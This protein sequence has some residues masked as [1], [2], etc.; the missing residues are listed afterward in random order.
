MIT[1]K[2]ILIDGENVCPSEYTGIDKLTKHD[3]IVVFN[4]VFSEGNINWKLLYKIQQ[5]PKNEQPNIIHLNVERKPKD[6]EKDKMDYYMIAHI[7]QLLSESKTLGNKLKNLFKRNKTEYCIISKDKGFDRY[8][9]YFKDIYSVTVLRFNNFNDLHDYYKKDTIKETT[10]L[11]KKSK[12]SNK[13]KKHS[14][15]DKNN[16]NSIAI[17]N[18]SKEVNNLTKLVKD[19][20]EKIEDNNSNNSYSDIDIK[21]NLTSLS[22]NINNVSIDS[23][24]SKEKINCNKD[25]NTVLYDESNYVDILDIDNSN[26]IYLSNF[27]NYKEDNNNTIFEY[28][29][30]DIQTLENNIKTFKPTEQFKKLNVK[31]FNENYNSYPKKKKLLRDG[32]FIKTIFTKHNLY[33]KYDNK[34]LDKFIRD[35]DAGLI[36]I[37]TMT[38][39]LTSSFSSAS[40]KDFKPALNE[41][42]KYQIKNDIM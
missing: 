38:K 42:I 27:K 39:R 8:A 10:S 4:S 1:K 28:T 31:K 41:I 20:S 33:N 25:I 23:L 36:N 22:N 29:N 35:C 24:I 32:L 3:T 7:T 12:S 17:T 21:D 26:V 34:S 11:N 13:S 18:L 15:I 37:K 19:L 16:N 5:K 14:S 9:D 6:N 40:I 2:Y 30:S